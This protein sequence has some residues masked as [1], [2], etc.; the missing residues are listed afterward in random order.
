MVVTT[1]EE[2]RERT[3]SVLSGLNLSR[4]YVEDSQSS[5]VPPG[6]THSDEEFENERPEPRGVRY[7]PTNHDFVRG[8]LPSARSR[9]STKIRELLPSTDMEIDRQDVS[10]MPPSL[11]EPANRSE[12][13]AQSVRFPSPLPGSGTKIGLKLTPRDVAR[14]R[15]GVGKVSP[16]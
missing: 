5:P 2:Y 10:E 15:R 1:G 8:H 6:T 4:V 11:V 3:L 7:V 12:E 13:N 16:R 9:R 14:D